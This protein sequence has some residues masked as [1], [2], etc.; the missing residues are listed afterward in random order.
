MK[1]LLSMA[2]AALLVAGSAVCGLA[3]CA[4][5]PAVPTPTV[6]TPTA[7]TGDVTFKCAMAGCTKTKA[8]NMKDPAPS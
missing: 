5:A 4:E 3:G 7:P 1:R 8:I 2:F 6:P